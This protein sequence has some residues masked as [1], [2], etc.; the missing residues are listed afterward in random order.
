LSENIY[1]MDDSILDPF[2]MKK[3]K[4]IESIKNMLTKLKEVNLNLF[5]AKVS[6]NCGINESTVRKYLQALETD[7]YIEIKNGKIILKSNQT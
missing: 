4:R 6:I 7:G 1:W 2:Q 5:L 3:R